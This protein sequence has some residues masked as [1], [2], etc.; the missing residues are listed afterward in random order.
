[1]SQKCSI[2]VIGLGQRG[3]TYATMIKNQPDAELAGLCD[4]SGDRL[5]AFAEELGCGDVP[6]FTAVEE[7]LAKCPCDAVVITS[8]DFTHC[9]CA[10]A[11][12]KAGKHVMLEKPMA[13]T[14]AE[15]RKIIEM[16][17]KYDRILQVGF[18]LRCLPL[19]KEVKSVL[20]SGTIGQLL[21][22][23][24]S[25]YVGTMHGASYMR[26]WHRKSAHTG[27]FLLAKCSHD[28][29]LMNQLAG[30][31]P[32]KI[33]SFG[34]RNFFH[35]EKQKSLHC[36]TCQEKSCRFRFQGEMVKMTPAEKANPTGRNFDLCV[37]NN[38]NDMVDNQQV[39]LEYFNGVR[40]TFSL[41]LFAPRPGR[42]WELI[43]TEGYILADT[44]EKKITVSFSDGR[45]SWSKICAANNKSAHDGSDSIFLD[46][47]V[48]CIINHTAPAAD[49]RAGLA[50]TV[51]GNAAEKSRLEKV[52]V[53]LSPSEYMMD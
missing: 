3:S 44:A 7:L 53:E 26:R 38:D 28:L 6:R 20:E 31:Y 15:C 4:V 24:F 5:N 48:N 21:S 35:P 2:A 32:A 14:A 50:A 30:S 11:A 40:G 16:S 34:D 13:P 46:E 49:A 17:K 9:Q 19:F 52:M 51:I 29:D 23:N 47:F 36:S 43:G 12:F 22:M 33:G 39:I 42:K 1:M 10:E 8:P 25:E 27:G 45:E 37:F 41:N 18:V